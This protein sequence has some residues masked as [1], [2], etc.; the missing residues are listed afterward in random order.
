MNKELKEFL[1]VKKEFEAKARKWLKN[2]KVPL[3]ERWDFFIESE[4]GDHESSIV[5]FKN[6]DNDVITGDN[7]NRYETIEISDLIDIVE[8]AKRNDPE[9]EYYDETMAKT[10]LDKLKEEILSRFIKSFQF[11]W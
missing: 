7:Y 11:D 9:D 4:L 3:E 5:E 10:N 8:D 1:K 2:K 6:L